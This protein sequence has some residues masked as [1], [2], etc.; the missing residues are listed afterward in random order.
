M[1]FVVSVLFY[2]DLLIQKKYDFLNTFLQALIEERIGETS[3]KSNKL[4]IKK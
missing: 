3:E 4:T 1:F 2:Q